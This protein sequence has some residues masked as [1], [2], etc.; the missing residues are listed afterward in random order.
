[1]APMNTINRT[2][3]FSLCLPLALALTLATLCITGCGGGGG[4]STT[5]ATQQETASSDTNSG[6]PLP[7]GMPGSPPIAP[8]Q[9]SYPA[10]P[11][12]EGVLATP[13]RTFV[14]NGGTY[15]ADQV[16][17]SFVDSATREQINALIAEQGLGFL[18]RSGTG[19]WYLLSVPDG[20]DVQQLV[21]RLRQLPLISRADLVGPMGSTGGF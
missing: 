9:T 7:P 20:V 3:R 19:S 18:F 16:D 13:Q 12:G 15:A 6:P 14:L 2:G 10:I 11:Q 17:V 5:A 1:M 4:A 8:V 21:V